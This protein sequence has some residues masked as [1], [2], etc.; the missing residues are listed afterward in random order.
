[1]RESVYGGLW[2]SEIV[3]PCEEERERRRQHVHSQACVCEGGIVIPGP[4]T[5]PHVVLHFVSIAN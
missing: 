4:P 3:H 1:M 2:V 5:L